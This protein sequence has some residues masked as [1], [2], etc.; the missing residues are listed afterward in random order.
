MLYKF[1]DLWPDSTLGAAVQWQC[2]SKAWGGPA[3]TPHG[4]LPSRRWQPVLCTGSWKKAL[5]SLPI[6]AGPSPY[7]IPALLFLLLLWIYPWDSSAILGLWTK[8]LLPPSLWPSERKLAVRGAGH[9]GAGIPAGAVCSMA[10]AV[11]RHQIPAFP[12]LA[13]CLVAA[14]ETAWPTELSVCCS[15]WGVQPLPSTPYHHKT[16][17]YQCCLLTGTEF[18]FLYVFKWKH[19]F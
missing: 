11:E 19:L 8:L 16:Q 9:P 3:C 5:A 12:L 6:M 14:E 2:R 13:R 4:L 1:S 17:D 10:A 18:H 15:A 7:N